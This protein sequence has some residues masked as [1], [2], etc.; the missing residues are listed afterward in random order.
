MIEVDDLALTYP[1][2]NDIPETQVIDGIDLNVEAGKSV[3]VIGPSGCGKSSLLYI[4]AGLMKPT[5]GQVTIAEE[6]V[7]RPRPDVALIL[8]DT[9]LLPWK[10]VWQNA[11]F[12]LTLKGP[13]SL[14]QSKRALKELGLKGM[15]HRY[16][17][18]LSGGEK[19]RVGL[20]R[21]LAQNAQVLLMDE[22]LAALDTLTKEHTQNLILALWKKH[23]FT[24][25]LVTHDIEEA[26]FF[27]QR[28]VA[29]SKRP[30]SIVD[31]I[32]NPDVGEEAYRQS[33]EFFRKVRQI[34][35]LLTS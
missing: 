34:R 32:D 21:A 35:A 13:M 8:Q 6:P 23:E 15:E 28:I 25:V 19:K 2:G 7:N 14:K 18:Q 12:G 27:G 17:S 1:G 16:P 10:T 29:L 30:A 9:G 26:V 22:P 3:A 33:S 31:E 4:L 5:A 11:I 20:A 24:L